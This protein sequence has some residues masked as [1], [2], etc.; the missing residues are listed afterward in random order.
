MSANYG[1]LTLLI[2]R[3]CPAASR[4]HA[5][6]SFS[7]HGTAPTFSSGQRKPLSPT[8]PPVEDEPVTPTAGLSSVLPL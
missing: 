2:S 7:R 3:R 1:A 6:R 5:S 8:Y 4:H